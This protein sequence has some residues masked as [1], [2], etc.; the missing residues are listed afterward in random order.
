[1]EDL[2]EKLEEFGIDEQKFKMIVV[3]IIVVILIGVGLVWFSMANKVKTLPEAE[4]NAKVQELWLKAQAAGAKNEEQ[5]RKYIMGKLK[6]VNTKEY[7]INV[8]EEGA[9]VTWKR[10]TM[11]K[12]GFFYEQPYEYRITDDK[13]NVTKY[14]VVFHEDGSADTYTGD[15]KT[16]YVLILDKSQIYR[17]IKY[18][19]RAVSMNN[20]AYQFSATGMVLTLDTFKPTCTFNTVHGIY[21]DY[22]YSM[23][24]NGVKTSLTV[25]SNNK[26]TIV[27]PEATE[28]L[29]VRFDSGEHRIFYQGKIMGV[30][31]M[32]GTKIV[33][34]DGTMVIEKTPYKFNVEVAKYPGMKV[35]LVEGSTVDT[36]K[37]GNPKTGDMVVYN[38]YTYVCNMHYVK[39]EWVLFNNDESKPVWGV[40]VDSQLYV[41]YPDIE[42]SLFGV[43]VTSMSYTYS[44]CGY[45]GHA[46]KIPSKVTNMAFAFEDCAG[47]LVAPKIPNGVTNMISTFDGCRSMLTSPAIPDSVTNM[48]A[49]FKNCRALVLATK[50]PANVT[51]IRETFENCRALTGVIRID[52]LKITE[53]DNC[54][55]DTRGEITLGGACPEETLKEYARTSSNNN[56]RLHS[57]PLEDE[58]GGF[59][60]I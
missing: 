16:G 32:D 60:E 31:S 49:T 10:K 14:A 4:L 37:A 3:G 29:Q 39:D 28:I 25:D 13:G 56:V 58:N 42:E 36:L 57:G 35:K 46:P 27:T 6:K 8:S 20:V 30:L 11:N 24:V 43:P 44:G 1:M 48:E 33:T 50:I 26:A 51:N 19:T 59:I 17:N 38:D 18:A 5:Y 34:D 55:K 53:Y 40:R 7:Y 21:R 22:T 52:S 47:I 54:F 2:L 41:S 12:Y 9:S 15:V 23:V 45:M